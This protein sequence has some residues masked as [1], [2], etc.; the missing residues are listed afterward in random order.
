MRSISKN[1]KKRELV[2]QGVLRIHRE[3][4]YLPAREESFC[5]LFP[6]TQNDGGGFLNWH[7]FPGAQ[8]SGKIQ[9]S[10]LKLM[11]IILIDISILLAI[12]VCICSN[13]FGIALV[14][15]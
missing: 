4:S 11:Y 9:D 2:N 7:C 1:N 6:R 3:G 14:C 8:G 15:F 12:H 13:I 5:Y 10:H